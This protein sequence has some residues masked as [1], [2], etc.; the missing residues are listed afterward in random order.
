[1]I[2]PGIRATHA[3]WRQ[4]GWQLLVIVLGL[5]GALAWAYFTIAGVPGAG[6]TFGDTAEERLIVLGAAAAAAIAIWGVVGQW[7]ISS[8]Q[9][10]IQFLRQIE[11][12]ADYL[13]GLRLFLDAAAA[14]DLR[15]YAYE[16]EKPRGWKRMSRKA[17][18]RCRARYSDTQRAISLVLNTDELVAI[19]VKNAILDYRLI[20]SYRRQTMIRRWNVAK[21]FVDALR[22]ASGP[23]TL[24]I[25]LERLAHRLEDDPYHMI[26]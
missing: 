4:P 21:G 15:K 22:T 6:E 19:G 17:K 25:E 3:V 16:F 1:M 8:R 7:S 10:T 5:A 2:K 14:G 24:W 12:D 11:T 13:K 26:L 9:L 23:H 20:C 18:R